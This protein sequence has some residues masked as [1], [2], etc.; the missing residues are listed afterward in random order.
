MVRIAI[1]DDELPA[2]EQ[3]REYIERYSAEK[4]LPVTIAA[5]LDGLSF[6]SDY[7]P[8]FD[9]VFIDIKM[10]LLDGF[11]TSKVLYKLDKN[12]CIVFVTNMAKYAVKGYEVDALYFAVKPISYFNISTVMTK[13]VGRI[14]SRREKEI[15]LNDAGQI[16][17]LPLSSVYYVEMVKHYAV[18][19]TDMGEY[20]ERARMEELEERLSPCAFARCNNGC[21]V[22]LRHVMRIGQDAVYLKAGELHIS[23]PRYKRFVSAFMSYL[24][25]RA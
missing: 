18:Y 20:R 8:V 14:E 17:R 22:N 6:I 2:V 12:V 3:L 19:H 15:L 4:G 16:V 23:R 21:L 13:A 9:I 24:G 7:K 25:G 5:F 10:P 1:V 11:E